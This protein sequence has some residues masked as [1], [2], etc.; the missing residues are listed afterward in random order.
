MKSQISLFDIGVI[1]IA[2]VIFAVI[3]IFLLENLHIFTKTVVVEVVYDTNEAYR[4][5]TSLLS[6]NYTSYTVYEMISYHVNDECFGEAVC[7]NAKVCYGLGGICR[8]S[9]SEGCCCYSDYYSASQNFITFLNS[10]IYYYFE[11]RP[12]C[13]KLSLGSKVLVE[14]RDENYSEDCK[15]T[16]FNAVVPIFVPYNKAELVEEL[17]LNYER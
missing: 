9:C 16:R 11:K 15:N 13:Y 10:S 8:F 6:L 7:T 3:S 14:F 4:F 5:L 1:A 12:K 17:Y 2:I